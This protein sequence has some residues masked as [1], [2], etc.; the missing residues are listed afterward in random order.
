M[1]C[2]RNC[3]RELQQPAFR[4]PNPKACPQ[5]GKWRARYRDPQ[6]RSRSH[7][8]SRKVDA[9]RFL[10]SV[11]HSKLVGS[12]VDRAPDETKFENW[13]EEWRAGVVHLAP[14]TLAVQ[15]RYTQKHLLPAFTGVSLAQID[16]AMVR[17]WVAGLTG[18][19]LAP[20]SV[21]QAAGIL[22]R[23]MA[24]A[25][26]SGVI[27]TSPCDGIKLPSNEHR[28]MRFLEPIRSLNSLQRWTSATKVSC[29]SAHMG[30]SGPA[31]SW[32]CAPSVSTFSAVGSRLLRRS[33][34]SRDTCTS[35]RP[36]PAQAVG[37][38]RFRESWWMRSTSTFEAT[39]PDLMTCVPLSDRRPPQAD[40]LAPA[41]RGTRPSRGRPSAASGSMISDTPRL[42]SG[43]RPAPRPKKS[44]PGRDTP[45][46]VSPSICTPT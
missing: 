7:N 25:V 23:I 2:F 43:S 41:G 18:S 21:R 29:F 28:V 31:S 33:S 17:N 32:G 13:A 14:S 3:R 19:G 12:Y 6:G 9:E 45:P 37:P 8:F 26:T 5:S 22:R 24:T 11:D 1:S 15:D 38:C 46:S 36:R 42:P 40:Q 34:T 44:R 20:A 4:L 27:P 39:P 10:V 30:A 16:H 35:G